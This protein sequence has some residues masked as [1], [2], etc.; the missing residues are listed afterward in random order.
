MALNTKRKFCILEFVQKARP[1]LSSN[2]SFLFSQKQPVKFFLYG[3]FHE[4]YVGNGYLIPNVIDF[5]IG[6]IM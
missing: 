5:Q 2:V 4:V 1:F 3:V 6:I